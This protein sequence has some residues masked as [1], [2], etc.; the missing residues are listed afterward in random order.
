MNNDTLCSLFKKSTYLRELSVG[1]PGQEYEGLGG[2]G[3]PAGGADILP[4]TVGHQAGHLGLLAA[5]EAGVV[6]Q[7]YT[8]VLQVVLPPLHWEVTK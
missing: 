7:D 4:Q 3:E 8:A 1:A 5:G 2:G 6:E